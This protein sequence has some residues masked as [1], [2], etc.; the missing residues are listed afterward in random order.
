M[1]TRWLDQYEFPGLAARAI[2]PK[3]YEVPTNEFKASG[4]IAND[5]FWTRLEEMQAY[6]WRYRTPLIIY[7]GESDEVVP[8]YIARMAESRPL[9]YLHLFPDSREAVV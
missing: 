9:S 2:K 8:V 1:V 6:R 4:T 5:A 3:A 7:Y